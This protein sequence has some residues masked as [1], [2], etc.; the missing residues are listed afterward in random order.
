MRIEIGGVYK[1]RTG[2][3]LR[4]VSKTDLMF[5]FLLIDKNNVLIPEKRNRFGHIVLRSLR[6]YSEEIMIG[7]KFIK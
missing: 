6:Q 1:T 5:N 7:F 4:L 2:N 3:Y